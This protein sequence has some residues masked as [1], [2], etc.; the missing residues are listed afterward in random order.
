[1]TILTVAVVVLA[2]L[3]VADL[4]VTFAALRRLREYGEQLTTAQPASPPSALELLGRDLPEVDVTTLDGVELAAEQLRG[5]PWLIGFFSATCAPCR[6]AARGFADHDEPDRLAVV[7]TDHATQNE[8]A[9][10]LELLTGTPHI[11]VESGS[12]GLSTAL[13]VRSFP[14]L[15]RTDEQGRVATAFDPPLPLEMQH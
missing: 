8:R 12:D 6:D 13:M 14:T 2:V 10:L 7:V 4:A 5:R 15:V 11:T 1:M 9:E 3:V